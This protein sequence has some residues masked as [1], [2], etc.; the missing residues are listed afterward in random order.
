MKTTTKAVGLSILSAFILAA[1]EDT[2]N[3]PQTK[4]AVGVGVGAV[5][6]AIAGTLAGDNKDSILVGAVAGAVVGGLI[7]NSLDKQE[8][9][10]RDSLSD[11]GTTITNTGSELIVTLPEGI[12]FGTDSTYVRESFRP[13]IYKIASNLQRHPDTT[14][15]VIGHTDS[16]GAASYNQ[17]L[18]TNRA[19][20]VTSLLTGK[21]VSHNRIASYGRGETS[22]VA[23]NDTESGKAKN[24]RVEIV[25]RPTT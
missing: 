11:D 9:E 23:T 12:T 22:P 20:S 14:V 2:T 6:G 7:G 18:S 17:A 25:I 13:E 10:L 21:G 5:T 15:D 24:R 4:T 8:A 19:N 16:T 3:G 1:C